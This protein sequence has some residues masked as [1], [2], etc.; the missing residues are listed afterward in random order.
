M[1]VPLKKQELDK[2]TAMKV[3]RKRFIL[4]VVSEAIMILAQTGTNVINVKDKAL[5]ILCAEY[6]NVF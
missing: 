6:N 2:S 1:K 5:N 4:Y 3:N